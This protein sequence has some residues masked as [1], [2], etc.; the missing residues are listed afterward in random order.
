[1]YYGELA[2]SLTVDCG[3]VNEKE[4]IVNQLFSITYRSVQSGGVEYM[5][6]N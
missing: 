2:G 6:E 5:F 1:L 3:K 4:I